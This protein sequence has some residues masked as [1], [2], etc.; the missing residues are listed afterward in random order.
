MVN[1]IWHHHFGRGIVGTL[2]NL[3]LVGDQPTH[4]ALLDWLAVEFLNRGWSM[5]E[6]HRLIMTS[7]A[8]QMASAFEHDGSQ[9]ADPENQLPWRYRMR[10]L[11]AETVRDAIMTA[12]GG[13]DLTV[14]G[15][16]VFPYVPEEILRSQAHGRWDNQPDGPHT[17]RRSV[18]VYRR[19]SLGLPFF[20]TFDLPDQ[21]VTAAARNVSTVPTQALTL[22]NNPFVVGQADLLAARL[23]QAAPDDLGRQIELA[24]EIALTRPPR[25]DEAAVARELVEQQSLLDFAHVM[26]N[27]NEFLYVR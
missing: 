21:N 14:G 7:E 18:Y 12:S 2:D 11:E 27:L 25:D 5:K 16:P 13:I 20:D 24:Y 3:G 4:P 19:R 15:L 8:Y 17:W 6:M 9:A 26:F 22:I 10:R 1:R 23:E